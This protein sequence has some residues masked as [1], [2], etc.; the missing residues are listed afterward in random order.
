MAWSA[1]LGTVPWDDPSPAPRHLTPAR[2]YPW[3]L[4][5]AAS[6][7]GTFTVLL[8]FVVLLAIFDEAPSAGVRTAGPILFELVLAG[9]STW[10]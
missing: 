4:L 1:L 8:G 7:S 5:S 2:P 10:A 9:G 6:V 3:F